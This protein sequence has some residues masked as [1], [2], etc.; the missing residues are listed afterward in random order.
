M[1]GFAEERIRVL[2]A[3][4]EA[5]AKPYVN[6]L[7]ATRK[8]VAAQAR[9]LEADIIANNPLPPNRYTGADRDVLIKWAK[10]TWAAEQKGAK[11]LAVRIP[12]ENWKRD[13]RW[14]WSVDAFYKIDTS[15]LQVQ[16]LF[17]HDKKLAVVRAINLYKNHLEG[18]SITSHPFEKADAELQ[19]WQIVRLDK[20]K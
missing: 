8:Q 7:S 10:E 20:I 14:R 16:L 1:L 9:T 11:V 4:D 12:S 17:K 19:P 2:Q 13:T 5:A 15:K 3:F 6:K 18:D